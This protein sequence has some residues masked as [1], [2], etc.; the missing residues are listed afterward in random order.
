[1]VE[2]DVERTQAGFSAGGRYVYVRD[3]ERA[4]FPIVRWE[5]KALAAGL[6]VVKI[7]VRHARDVEHVTLVVLAGKYVTWE[8][9]CEKADA[10]NRVYRQNFVRD[11]S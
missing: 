4:A 8:Q 10:L 2:I 9:V 7:E 1:M 3:T 5:A 11:P 6:A